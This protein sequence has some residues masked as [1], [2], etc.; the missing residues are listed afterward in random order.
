MPAILTTSLSGTPISLKKSASSTLFVPLPLTVPAKR[1]F[2][3]TSG[4]KPTN[5][6][7]GA[8]TLLLADPHRRETMPNML[9]RT[10]VYT[11]TP[12]S[13]AVVAAEVEQLT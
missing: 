13:G 6:H 11:S 5:G 10:A 12:Q 4:E 2:D 9:Q 7:E 8:Q 3:N 1:T